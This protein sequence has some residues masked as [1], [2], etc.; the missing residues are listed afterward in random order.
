AITYT[1]F[2]A[3]TVKET[4]PTIENGLNGAWLIAVVATQSIAVLGT[5]VAPAFFNI[6]AILFFAFCMFL[7]GCMLYIFIIG[8][9][10]YRWTFFRMT[11]PQLTP[12]Y[13]VNMRD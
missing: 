13:W 8:L 2:T 4:K 6:S 10:F 11:P 9:I 7:L 3:V 1:F 12:P 5:L